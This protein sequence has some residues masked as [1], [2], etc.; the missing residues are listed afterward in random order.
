MSSTR[1]EC[2]LRGAGTQRESSGDGGECITGADAVLSRAIFVAK[3][4]LKDAPDGGH[5]RGAAGE[6]DAIDG[7]VRDSRCGDDFGDSLPDGFEVVFD[8][9]FEVLAGDRGTEVETGFVE[10]ELCLILR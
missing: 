4:I 3:A 8:P 1:S 10:T 6:E 2:R 5:E 7:G 9:G